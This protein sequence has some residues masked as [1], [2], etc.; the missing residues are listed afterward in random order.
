MSK[1]YAIKLST[2]AIVQVEDGQ[3]ASD[4]EFLARLERNDIWGDTPDI[5]VTTVEEITD[6]SQLPRHAGWDGLCL[7]YGGD[8][9]TRLQDL[10]PTTKD[11]S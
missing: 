2:I 6:Q 10:I 7:P 9:N 1:F 5:E 8:G 3:D 4:A 11:K